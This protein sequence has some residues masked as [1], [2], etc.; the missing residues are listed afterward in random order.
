MTAGRHAEDARQVMQALNGSSA[1]V[2][3]LVQSLTPVVRARV[4]RVLL[5]RS[6]AAQGRDV[7]QELD[8]LT[9]DVFV[10]L[11]EQ[12]GKVLLSVPPWTGRLQIGHL[13]LAMTHRV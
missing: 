5:R 8:D 11:F 1:A 12:K 9:Q 2:R 3:A 6:G 10:A 13:R 7:R 4:A